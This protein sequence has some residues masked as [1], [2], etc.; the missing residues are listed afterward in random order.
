MNDLL[1]FVISG[2]VIG[3]SYYLG[4]KNGNDK[5]VKEEIRQFLHE[6]TVSKMAHD[7]F[8]QRAKNETR[9]FLKALGAEDIDARKIRTPKLPKPEE[10]DSSNK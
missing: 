2:T 5:K 3:L 7:I 9:L 4:F 1:F 10:F 6:V 8:M